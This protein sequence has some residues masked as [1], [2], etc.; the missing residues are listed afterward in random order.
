MMKKLIVILALAW[1]VPLAAGAGDVA[2]LVNLGFSPDSGHFMFGFY[3]FDIQ[4]GKPY[5]EL[6]IVDTK[7]NNFVP[8]GTFKGLYAVQPQPGWNPAGAFYRLFSDANATAR[9]YGIDHLNQGRLVYLLL[10]GLSGPDSLSFKD[11]GTGFQWEVKLNETIE[12]TSDAVSSFFGLELEITDTAGKKTSIKAGN[13]SIKR[14]GIEN[15]TIREILVAGDD[16]TVVILIERVERTPRGP[17]IRYMVE[18]FRL[19]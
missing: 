14:R 12:K 16:K 5:A 10:D 19:P 18:T 6:F 11:F 7:R 1:V 15:Y 13:P 8:G 2:N 3:G 4:S 9:K 17:S